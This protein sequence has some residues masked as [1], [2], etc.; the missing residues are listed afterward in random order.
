MQPNYNL[1]FFSKRGVT[2]KCVTQISL[3]KADK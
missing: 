2:K 1:Q 3:L